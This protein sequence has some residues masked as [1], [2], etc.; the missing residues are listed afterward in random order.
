MFQQRLD[1]LAEERRRPWWR[2][3]EPDW[4]GGLPTASATIGN[5]SM[6]I[7]PWRAARAWPM[8]LQQSQIATDAAARG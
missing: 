4:P 1:A 3:R 6:K 5:L 2:W 8:A 7:V